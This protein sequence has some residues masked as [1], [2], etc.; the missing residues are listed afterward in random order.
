MW[1][2]KCAEAILSGIVHVGVPVIEWRARAGENQKS[3]KV[4][5][6]EHIDVDPLTQV[7]PVAHVA[8]HGVERWWR[9]IESALHCQPA[10][11]RRHIINARHC[12]RDLLR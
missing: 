7:T 10:R 1:S 3:L 9:L 2:T 4:R 6:K 12:C 5:L 11:E 8:R